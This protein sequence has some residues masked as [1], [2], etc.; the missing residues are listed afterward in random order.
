MTT[1]Q[2]FRSNRHPWGGALPRAK[3]LQEF[4]CRILSP[5][6]EFAH[7]LFLQMSPRSLFDRATL[8]HYTLLLCLALAPCSRFHNLRHVPDLRS[9]R[10]D[11]LLFWFCVRIHDYSALLVSYKM[12]RNRG[13]RTVASARRLLISDS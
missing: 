13:K 10:T 5:L 9:T 8:S 4:L 2:T 6:V 11:V 12:N 3:R 7:Q 1:L